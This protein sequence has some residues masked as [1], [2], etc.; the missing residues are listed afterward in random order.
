VERCVGAFL[1]KEKEESRRKR[2]GQVVV[3]KGAYLSHKKKEGREGYISP[4]KEGNMHLFRLRVN[5]IVTERT[6]IW[7]E[8]NILAQ[9]LLSWEKGGFLE[10]PHQRGGRGD[11]AR[12]GSGVRGG[13][14]HWNPSGLS[15]WGNKDSRRESE[16]PIPEGNDHVI[17]SGDRFSQ[18]RLSFV[19][20]FKKRGKD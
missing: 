19:Q 12:A 17:P 10:L 1:I 7:R 18:S 15:A 4:A 2:E 8:S 13:K 20:G 5:T 9:N 6:H 11:S 3:R 16:R 14:K